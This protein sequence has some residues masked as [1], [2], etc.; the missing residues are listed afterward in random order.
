LTGRREV[1]PGCRLGSV[2][3]ALHL[4][5]MGSVKK[6][7][8]KFVAVFAGGLLATAVLAGVLQR[9]AIDPIDA[10]Y[11]PDSEAQTDYNGWRKDPSNMGAQE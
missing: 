6:G 7:L 4:L 5:S 8:A 2:Q 9:D 11:N 3:I 1:V 10:S